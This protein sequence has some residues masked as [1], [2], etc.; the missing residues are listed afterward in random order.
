LN[1]TV[2]QG[3]VATLLRCG[4]IV[5][6]HLIANLLQ[7]SPMKELFENWSTFGEVVGKSN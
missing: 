1:T 4:V 6:E 3:S 5:N 7:S 2:S